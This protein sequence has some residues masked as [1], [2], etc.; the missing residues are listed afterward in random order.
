M[1]C[2]IVGCKEPVRFLHLR[3]CTLHYSLYRERIG[4][5]HDRSR[6]NV[7]GSPSYDPSQSVDIIV[8]SIENPTAITFDG[9]SYFLDDEGVYGLAVDTD[10]YLYPTTDPALLRYYI[11]LDDDAVPYIID[12]QEIA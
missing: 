6:Y 12:A 7:P 1:T 9:I 8:E 4:I 5:F 10:G 3:L 2:V 11:K